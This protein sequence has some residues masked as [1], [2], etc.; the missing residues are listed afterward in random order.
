[1]NLA[2][3]ALPTFKCLP[4]PRGQH[5]TTAHLLPDE[6]E[7]V[8]VITQGFAD[9]QAGRLPDFPTSEGARGRRGRLF[10][11][12]GAFGGVRHLE[13]AFCWGA[14]CEGKVSARVRF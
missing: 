12:V 10:P 4:E 14:I 6:S 11:G 1:M 7:V 8:D 5:G 13:G 2:L 9:V 3:K